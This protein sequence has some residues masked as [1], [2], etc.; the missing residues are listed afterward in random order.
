MDRED[1]AVGVGAVAPF[2]YLTGMPAAKRWSSADLHAT[3]E[4]VTPD[5]LAL[6]GDGVP[7][8]EA[9]IVAALAAR[10]PKEDVKRTV[11]RLAV[12]GQL[13]LQGSRYILPAAET[14]PG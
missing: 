13:A 11:M 4:R 12:L 1:G 6:L 5:V 14:E 2:R 9:A 10:H 3:I 8:S 7:R